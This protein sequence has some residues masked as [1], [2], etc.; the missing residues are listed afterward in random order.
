MNLPN[1]CMPRSAEAYAMALDS[2]D[3][4]HALHYQPGWGGVGYTHCNAVTADACV[5]LGVRLPLLKANLN[6]D[7][8]KTQGW[9]KLVSRHAAVA[10]AGLGQP[11]VLSWKN[12]KCMHCHKLESEHDDQA[13]AFEA[14]HGHIA[15]LRPN[16]NICQAGAHNFNDAPVEKG[17][18]QLEPEMFTHA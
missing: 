1:A 9:V 10:A 11:T 7:A 2:L 15:M 4:E 18:G 3:V 12:P 16:G 13:H 14:G 6:G 5:A 8:G 17:F